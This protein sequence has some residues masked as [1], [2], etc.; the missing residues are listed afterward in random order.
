MRRW[1]PGACAAATGCSSRRVWW[2]LGRRGPAAASSCAYTT[3]TPNAWRSG[4]DCGWWCRVGRGPGRGARAR[5]ARRCGRQH[6]QE[7][8][9]QRLFPHHFISPT[10]SEVVLAVMWRRHGI[11]TAAAAGAGARPREA[12]AGVAHGML[13]PA[14]VAGCVWCTLQPSPP[15]L[16]TRMSWRPAA[17]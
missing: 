1:W 14:A 5:R 8:Q 7:K 6:I 11:R 17:G 3:P 12:T 2:E 16:G 15:S 10:S 9:Q 4:C 13:G